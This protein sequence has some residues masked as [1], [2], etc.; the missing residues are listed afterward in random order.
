MGAKPEKHSFSMAHVLRANAIS[1]MRGDKDHFIAKIVSS[2]FLMKCL[3]MIDLAIWIV[4]FLFQVFCCGLK[5]KYSCFHNLAH[6]GKK[7]PD[8]NRCDCGH[9]EEYS[10]KCK[11]HVHDTHSRFGGKGLWGGGAIIPGMSS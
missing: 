9:F 10:K 11:I 3:Q 4:C 6:S 2:T 8:G 7:V 5:L 1:N